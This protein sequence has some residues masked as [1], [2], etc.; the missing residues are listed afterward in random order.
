MKHKCIA[1][2]VFCALLTEI[3]S[4]Q[5]SAQSGDDEI[6]GAGTLNFIARFSA[7]RRVGNSVI[8]QADGNVG[9][10]TTSPQAKLDV[11]GTGTLSIVGSTSSGAASAT[12]VWGRSAGTSGN[13]VLGDATAT[14][15]LNHGVYGRSAS[16]DGIG[17]RGDASSKTGNAYGLFGTT[18]TTGFG[19]GVFGS[20][21][22]SDGSGFGVFGESDGTS[23]NGTFG[24]ASATSGYTVG[25]SGYV[26]SPTGTAGRFVAH[27]G[28]GL[29]LQGISGNNQV[30]SVDAGGNAF[31]AGNLSKGSGSFKIDHPLDPANKYLSHSFVE[32]PD[33]MNVYNGVVMLDS[34]GSAWVDLPGYF[35]ALNCEYRYQLTSIGAPGPNLYVAKE[36]SYNRFKIA[37]GKRHGKVSWQVTGI[38]QDAYAKAHRIVVEE[39]K[40]IAARGQFLHPE[41]FG[42]PSQQA[43]GSLHPTLVE[44]LT[45]P[46]ESR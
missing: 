23:G 21:Y 31:F 36:I 18:A 1:V 33:M 30:F 20:A 14:T 34:H 45:I 13:G 17:V 16:P 35:E 4:A 42:K 41:L 3:A 25:V 40:P 8:F 37:G 2:F 44:P 27:A 19:A 28:S 7:T 22:A 24:Y 32:S 46:T 29:I 26:E 43:I 6:T 39:E 12:G 38:R 15:G 11:E 10:G 9:V 5:T